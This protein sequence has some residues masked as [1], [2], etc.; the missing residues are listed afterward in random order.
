MVPTLQSYQQPFQNTTQNR[1]TSSLYSRTQ[2]HTIH[3]ISLL[4]VRFIASNL[5]AQ[6]YWH[7][8]F[9]LKPLQVYL[10]DSLTI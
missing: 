1:G 5:I 6:A 8:D 4:I 9:V 7:F 2:K 10:W 3:D